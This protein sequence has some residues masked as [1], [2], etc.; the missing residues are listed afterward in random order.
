MRFPIVFRQFR[1]VAA[2]GV[3]AGVALWTFKV[4]RAAGPRGPA[5]SRRGEER[6]R[7]YADNARDLV[8]RY[9]FGPK[10]GF[11]YISPSSIAITGYTPEEHYADPELGIR[12]LHP[13]DRHLL[14]GAVRSPEEPLVLRWYRKDGTLIWTEQRNRLVYD[15]AKNVIAIDGIAWDV[16]GRKLAEDALRQSEERFRAA[17]GSAALG[18][19]LASPEGRWM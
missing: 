16:T 5:R 2:G 4:L 11:E 10:P 6:L 19:A 17:F 13:D 8:Y 9:R 12:H 1:R 14:D 15:E 3:M 7:L 18:M